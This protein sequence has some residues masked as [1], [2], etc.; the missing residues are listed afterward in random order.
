M[1]VISPRVHGYL[2]FL[3][4]AIFLLAPDT[5][6]IKSATSDSRLYPGRG[7]FNGDA[8]FRFSL[9]SCQAHSIYHSWLD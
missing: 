7:S 1:K 2:D 9:W 5:I 4:V 6:R 3:T 8:G